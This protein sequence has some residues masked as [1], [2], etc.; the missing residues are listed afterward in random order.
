MSFG[1][2]AGDIGLLVP[3]AAKIVSN[4]RK[5]CGEHAELTQQVSGLRSIL[6]RLEE[7]TKDLNGEAEGPRRIYKEELASI[8]GG[9]KGNLEKLDK[10][11]VKYN[12]LSDQERG[13]TKLWRRVRFG[14]GEMVDVADLRGKIT[15]YTSALGL[16]INIISVGQVGRVEKQ[17]NESGQDLKKIQLA[18]ND[19]TAY[20]LSKSTSEGSELSSRWLFQLR[21]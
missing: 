15:Y 14:N 6:Q 7:E 4:S 8:A 20:F 17:M 21:D 19:I 16:Y 5:A 9:C 2:S 3:L 13:A 1:F 18:V 12:S 11:L 10:I